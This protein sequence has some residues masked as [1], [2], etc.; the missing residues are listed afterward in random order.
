MPFTITI[1]GETITVTNRIAV[2]AKKK[3]YTYTLDRAPAP[4]SAPRRRG[5]CPGTRPSRTTTYTF[6]TIGNITGYRNL[7]P[8]TGTP[9]AASSAA[10]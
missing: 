4:R 1:D 6:D 7:L 10:R 9:P 8:T 2:N 5:R 3:T